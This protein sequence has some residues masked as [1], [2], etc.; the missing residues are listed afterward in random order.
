L[1]PDTGTESFDLR[2]PGDVAASAWIP[3][4]WL[5][6]PELEL[7]SRLVLCHV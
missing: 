6:K 2:L 1:S 5:G 3:F 7:V 4:L